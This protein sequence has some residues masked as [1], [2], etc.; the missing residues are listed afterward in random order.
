MERCDLPRQMVEPARM[1]SEQLASTRR[2]PVWQPVVILLRG[3]DLPAH[4]EKHD[5]YNGYLL[6]PA[7]DVWERSQDISEQFRQGVRLDDAIRVDE[8][9]EVR[10]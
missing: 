5:I 10:V 8:G 9:G 4:D 7:A 1:R 2:H 6:R 3:L